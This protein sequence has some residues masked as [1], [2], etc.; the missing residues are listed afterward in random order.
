MN[1]YKAANAYQKDLKG[2]YK[3]FK[4]YP[5]KALDSAHC[6]TTSLWEKDKCWAITELHKSMPEELAISIYSQYVARW[7]KYVLVKG[8]S[9]SANIWL[10]KRIKMVKVAVAIFP[11]PISDL[12]HEGMRK[13]TAQ[14][15]C[16]KCVEALKD[17]ADAKKSIAEAEVLVQL[18]A[19]QWG[20]A[21]KTPTQEI[22]PLEGESNDDYFQRVDNEL[23]WFRLTRL[24]DDDWWERKIDQA[25][26]QFCEHCQIINGRV[27][28]GVSIYLSDAGLR[29]FR[30]RKL[31]S[32]LALSKMVARN[33]ETG[34]EINMLDVVKTSIAN[35]AIRRHELM[36]RM[37]GFEDI[38]Q[39]NKLIGGFFTLTAPS[40]YHAY[41]VTKKGRSVENKHYQGFSP[42]QTQQYLSATWAKARAKLKRLDIPL[43]GF[44]VCEPHHDG[45][46]HWH[47]LFFFQPDHE[48]MIRYVLADYFT[49]E[50]REELNAHDDEFRLWGRSFDEND[51][52][53]I[54]LFGDSKEEETALIADIEKRIS[55]RFDY[56]VI[57][58]EKGSATGYIAK[59]IAKNIDGYKM[60]DDEETGAPA[61]KKAEA[62][63]GWSSL[64]RIRQ[65]QQ[66]GGP[67]VSVWRELRRLE[68]DAEVKEAKAV[69]KENGEK[70]EPKIR[71]FFDLQKE[72]DSIEVA[73]LAAD[74]GN[75]SMYVHA[76]GGIFC[77][78]ADHPIRMVYKPVG[79]AY[80]EE[81][82]KL[83]GIGSFDKT[84]ITH[85]E[86]WVITKKLADNVGF[87]LEKERQLRPWSSVNN[88]T[89]DK[90]STVEQAVVDQFKQLGVDLDPVL[91]GPVMNGARILT[92]DGR[93]ASIIHSDLGVQLR[94]EEVVTPGN[95]DIG[96][97]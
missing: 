72:H 16:G 91:L 29:E 24:L 20:F 35:P 33:E 88:C 83:K 49:Q 55:A 84:M 93:R 39:E 46:P 47:A 44:R 92:G 56:K 53:A 11:V 73:R 69:A 67:P 5:T 45:T 23:A 87:E 97:E 94:V 89:G 41:T 71:S 43:M 34:E 82:K 12:K 74:S 62:V 21:P 77:P 6:G 14:I 1:Q 37:R 31:A 78:R 58:P 95:D 42:K 85:A 9:R 61:D 8:A 25:Y 60:S 86:G 27:R 65:F 51:K 30:A 32:T 40:K 28:K 66:I 17:A 26:R 7:E 52:Q 10:R 57:D 70:Y 81:V 90:N 19:A 63:C 79:N 3:N 2:K 22:E 48:Q 54:D 50:D 15:W 68:Q 80:G 18:F 75:W 36:V 38:A 4:A 96:W 13:N 76:M 59:Y 64:W